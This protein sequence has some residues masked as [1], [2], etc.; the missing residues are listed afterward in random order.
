MPDIVNFDQGACLFTP[1]YTAYHA[2]HHIGNTKPGEFVLVHGA[3]GG[4][5]LAAVQL[6]ASHGARVIGT[7]SSKEGQQ[8]VKEAG[9]EYVVS[10]REDG[11]MDKIVEFTGGKGVDVILEMLASSNL[12]MIHFKCKFILFRTSF[13][14]PLPLLSPLR[15]FVRGIAALGRGP[16][17]CIPCVN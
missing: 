4:V 13:L 15:L 14:D 2:L 17:N 11:Y 10:H 7:A 9:A 1:A 12:G 3:S 6:A 5:G 8:L 16:D